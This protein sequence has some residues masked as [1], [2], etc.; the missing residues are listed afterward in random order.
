MRKGRKM[1]KYFQQGDVLIVPVSD[2]NEDLQKKEDNIV[3]EGEATGH[4]HRV[5]GDDVE[6]MVGPN[7]DIFVSA[8]KGATMTHD[9][10]HTINLPV[11]KFKIGIVQEYDPLEDEVREVRD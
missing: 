4:M 6:V 7:G 10:H 2:I 5:L 3:A 1:D 9:E 11:G 8:P